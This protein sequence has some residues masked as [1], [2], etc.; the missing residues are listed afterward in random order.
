MGTH[1]TSCLPSRDESVR[2]IIT[3]P[4]YWD[5]VDYGVSGQIGQSSYEAFLENLI[6]VFKECERTLV[7]NGK[8]CINTPIV[9][10]PKQRSPKTQH[11][12]ELKN[13]NNDIEAK[14]LN[15]TNLER[16][17]LYV[18]QKANHRKDVRVLSISAQ[19]L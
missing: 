11:T 8:L 15:E 1:V 16:F 5:L 6:T 2:L 17:S 18:W 4:P 10:V 7:P 14:V 13:L 12:R 19:H 9:P 3:S